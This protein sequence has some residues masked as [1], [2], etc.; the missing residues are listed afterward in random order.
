MLFLPALGNDDLRLKKAF[1]ETD[2]SITIYKTAFRTSARSDWMDG[3][4]NGI[5]LKFTWNKMVWV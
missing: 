1:L 3:V 5:I 2:L 4:E